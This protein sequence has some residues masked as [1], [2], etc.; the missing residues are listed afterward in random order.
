MIRRVNS[1]VSAL[2]SGMVLGTGFLPACLNTVFIVSFAVMALDECTVL[3]IGTLTGGSRR[4]KAPPPPP[5]QFKEPY[6]NY[7]DMVTCKAHSC[8]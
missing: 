1:M 8:L 2:A 6:G 7:K 3:R 5:V 4:R